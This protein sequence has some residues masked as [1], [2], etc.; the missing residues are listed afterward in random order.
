MY[1]S[2]KIKSLVDS[3]PTIVLSLVKY[4][5]HVPATKKKRGKHA[6]HMDR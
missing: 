1:K 2:L 6:P 5:A 3:V 4:I